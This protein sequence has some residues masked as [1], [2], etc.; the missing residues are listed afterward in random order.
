MLIESVKRSTCICY[1]SEEVEKTSSGYLSIVGLWTQKQNNISIFCLDLITL[2][3]SSSTL[4]AL[5]Y[6]LIRVSIIIITPCLLTTSS[7]LVP[8]NICAVYTV[9]TVSSLTFTLANG[10]V[11]EHVT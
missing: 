4:A 1:F 5:V 7:Y 8:I 3:M 6:F 10:L 11:P 9:S 2:G